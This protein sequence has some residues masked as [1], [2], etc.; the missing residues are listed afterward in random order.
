MK[1]RKQR[2][3]NKIDNFL[4]K[5]INHSK[6]MNV[7]LIPIDKNSY[8]MF[9]KYKVTDCGHFF[10]VSTEY[11]TT[12]VKTLSNLKTA[13]TWCVFNERKKFIDC[14]K[15][16]QLDFKLAS[17]EIDLIQKTKVLGSIKDEG[18]KLAYVSKIEEDI[19]KKRILNNQLNR[20]IMSSKEWQMKKFAAS[21]YSEK[22]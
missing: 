21:K 8:V 6:A 20:Y 12:N 14:K 22:R 2:N 13:I 3:K 16:E 15:I 19:L 11:D 7:S 18:Y 17:L 1:N 5:Q 9:S 4:K 10:E